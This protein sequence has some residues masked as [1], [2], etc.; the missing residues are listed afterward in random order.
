M[1]IAVVRS[2]DE[3]GSNWSM[4]GPPIGDIG[5]IGYFSAGKDLCSRA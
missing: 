3:L 1:Q 2:A 5:G 4:T